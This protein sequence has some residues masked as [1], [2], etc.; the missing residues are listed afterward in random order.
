MRFPFC[1]INSEIRPPASS[2]LRDTDVFILHA[3]LSNHQ[4]SKQHEYG[5]STAVGRGS[6][7]EKP[8]PWVGRMEAEEAGVRVLGDVRTGSGGS[9]LT[10]FL[11]GEGVSW[12]R[13]LR[14]TALRSACA[15]RP[16]GPRSIAAAAGP[17]TMREPERLRAGSA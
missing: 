3:S 10:S 8:R 6:V 4:P 14:D 5:K 13:D 2:S 15:K 11:L 16:K 1:F 7:A 12:K 17:G 9:N